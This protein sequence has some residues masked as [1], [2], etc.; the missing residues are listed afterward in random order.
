MWPLGIRVIWQPNADG[1]KMGEMPERPNHA[2]ETEKSQAKWL[3]W[4]LTLVAIAGLFSLT[5]TDWLV[6]WVS[7]W[8]TFVGKVIRQTFG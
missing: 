6:Q 8:L 1:G 7:D 5:G 3:L 2:P 4:T